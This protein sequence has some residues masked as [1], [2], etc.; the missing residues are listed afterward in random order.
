MKKEILSKYLKI[1][2]KPKLS[3]DV[4]KIEY[5]TELINGKLVYLLLKFR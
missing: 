5:F 1:L 2:P 3:I 4:F